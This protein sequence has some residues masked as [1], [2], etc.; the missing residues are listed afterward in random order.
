MLST[1]PDSNSL[2]IDTMLCY[3]TEHLV[4]R[5]IEL[6]D[7]WTNGSEDV[8]QAW[9]FFVIICVMNLLLLTFD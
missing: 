9:H 7:T 3:G 4:T 1:D 2:V 8:P 5:T 6:D